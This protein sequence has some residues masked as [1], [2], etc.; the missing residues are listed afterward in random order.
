[1]DLSP[2][3]EK[4][5]YLLFTKDFDE[6]RLICE[7]QSG[8]YS[9]DDINDAALQYVDMCT[10]TEEFSLFENLSDGELVPNI[11]SS[12]LTETI[13]VLLDFGLDPNR[14]SSE[15]PLNIIRCITF[16]KNGYQAA[17][18]LA[19]L[20]EHGGNPSIIVDEESVIRDMNTDLLLDPFDFPYWYNAF[21]HC[22]MVFIGYGARLENGLEC[23][24][25]N[26]GFDE[27]VFRNHRQFCY[28]WIASD[29]SD[30]GV[31]LCF[32]DKTSGLEVARY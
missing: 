32:Y 16:I 11:E 10:D 30:D 9:T 2:N 28:R 3:A 20:F 21:V 14:V 8:I 4:L 22:W 18:A 6:N 31:E 17:D 13:R 24:D 25:M 15:W 23:I 12:H 7:L 27:K 19:L 29:R 1:M 5:F 26:P